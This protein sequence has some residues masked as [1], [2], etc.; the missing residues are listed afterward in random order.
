MRVS[1]RTLYLVRTHA[2]ESGFTTKDAMLSLTTAKYVRARPRTVE[3]AFSAAPLLSWLSVGDSC[4]RIN[5]HVLCLR[6]SFF[7]NFVSSN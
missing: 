2:G 6:T 3:R 4:R 7:G 5:L 1:L